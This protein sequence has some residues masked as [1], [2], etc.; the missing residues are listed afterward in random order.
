MRRTPYESMRS[1]LDD[2][3]FVF[4]SEDNISPKEETRVTYRGE[5]IHN[6]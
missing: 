4:R 3:L 1:G 6:Y 2:E 5:T